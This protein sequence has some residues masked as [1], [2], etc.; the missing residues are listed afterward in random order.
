MRF[1]FGIPIFS[2]SSFF[3]VTAVVF[4]IVK[5]SGLF[6]KLEASH[7]ESRSHVDLILVEIAV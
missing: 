4:E 3:Q 2:K 6:S 5:L 1:R 7:N